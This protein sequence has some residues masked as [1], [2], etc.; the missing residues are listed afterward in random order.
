[1]NTVNILFGGDFAPCRRYEDLIVNQKVD[2]FSG[3]NHILD[4]VDYSFLNLET[5]LTNSKK[6]IIKD[7]PCIKANPKTKDAIRRFNMASVAN[8]HIFDYGLDGYIDTID[9]CKS[10]GVDT[11]GA[12]KDL[13]AALEIKILTIKKIK[14]CFIALAESEFNEPINYMES[15]ATTA[16]L[17]PVINWNQIVEAKSK[18]DFLIVSIHGGNEY[19][20]LPRPGL[21]K[22]CHHFVDLGV[23]AIICHHSHVPGA[24]EVYNGSPIFYSLGNLIFD[25]ESPPINWNKSFLVKLNFTIN[26]KI[27]FEL[28]PFEQSV[29]KKGLVLLE[30]NEKT[31][32]FDYMNDINN[33]LACNIK[34][35]KEWTKFVDELNMNLKIRLFSPVFKFPGLGLLFRKSPMMRLLLNKYNAATKLNVIKCQSH[36]EAILYLIDKENK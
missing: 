1:M 15:V 8:N 6:C 10:I 23:D 29:V 3:I 35:I 14:F 7:G 22:L 26:R 36:R 4:A 11:I 32:F 25:H 30:D 12:G 20:P 16:P 18:C 21:K 34:F 27:D 28:I 33:K 31:K 9:N 19:Y 5:P 13:N 17:D 24:Y 2:V